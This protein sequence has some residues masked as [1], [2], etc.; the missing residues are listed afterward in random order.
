MVL[1]VEVMVVE[2][3]VMVEMVMV[4]VVVV[5]EVEERV[6][7]EVGVLVVV[8]V[9]E[10]MGV[11]SHQRISSLARG[12][13]LESNRWVEQRF[14]LPPPSLP[15]L[16]YCSRGGREGEREGGRERESTQSY[17]HLQVMTQ[18]TY[19]SVVCQE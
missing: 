12:A 13:A 11:V 9:V 7:F 4:V 1:E 2:V 3:E 15:P 8:V 18:Q 16:L 19:T 14:S 6:V 5:V 10:E 17:S